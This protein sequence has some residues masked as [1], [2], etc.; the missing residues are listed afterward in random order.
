MALGR[1]GSEVFSSPGNL[2]D[3][4]EDVVRL[5]SIG[6]TDFVEPGRDKSTIMKKALE[7]TREENQSRA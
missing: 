5:F 6:S 7:W 1:V 3:G 2:F 4:D